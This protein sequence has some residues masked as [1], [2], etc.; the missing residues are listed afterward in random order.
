MKFYTSYYGNYRNIPKN[1]MC[2]GISLYCPENLINSGHEN[3]M[4]V[5]GNILAP[6]KCLLDDI[7]SGKETEDGYKKRYVECLLSRFGE[8][9][10]YPTFESFIRSL[11][12]NYELRYDAIVFMCYEKPE[13][14][15]HRHI[16]RNLMNKI[17]HIPCEEYMIEK[18]TKKEKALF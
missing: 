11:E 9:M 12:E 8:G 3:F 4:F 5:E 6:D 2:I 14:F 7:K 10:R 15:C 13:D 16:V 18:E 17:F 1:Y